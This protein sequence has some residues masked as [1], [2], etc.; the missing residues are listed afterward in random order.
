MTF[1]QQLEDGL[2]IKWVVEVDGA[3]TENVKVIE[4]ITQLR[5]GTLYNFKM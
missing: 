5:A 4:N 2:K 1:P 3:A